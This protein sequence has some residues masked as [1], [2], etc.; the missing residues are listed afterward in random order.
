MSERLLAL[1]LDRAK[2][3]ADR[4]IVLGA[5]RRFAESINDTQLV[6]EVQAV[7]PA[8]HPFIPPE[9]W[10]QKYEGGFRVHADEDCGTYVDDMGRYCVEFWQEHLT[11]AERQAR[12]V[13]PSLGL[14]DGRKDAEGL[15]GA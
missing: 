4:A 12:L 15:N 8:A 5:I 3:D 2:C 10:K 11:D 1:G 13:D 9:A 7:M 6:A 14:D